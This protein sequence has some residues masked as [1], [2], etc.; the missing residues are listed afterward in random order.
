MFKV[1][2]NIV[3]KVT[4][5]HAG[6]AMKPSK[7]I[8]KLLMGLEKLKFDNNVNVAKQYCFTVTREARVLRGD[9]HASLVL[10]NFPR[11]SITRRTNCN[12]EII[13]NYLQVNAL[14]E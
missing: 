3:I 1:R 4:Q 11:A 7:C 6:E 10:S 13:V 5:F 9:S 14:G 12:N 8:R 2:C